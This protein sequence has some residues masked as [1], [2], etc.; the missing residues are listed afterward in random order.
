MT[1]NTNHTTLSGFIAA[2]QSQLNLNDDDV[3]KAM[4]NISTQVYTMIKS[5]HAK[6]PY[7]LIESLA[8][9]LQMAKADLLTSVLGYE[10]PALL[11]LVRQTWS[12][13]TLTRN[14]RTL[15]EAFRSLTAG[16]DVTPVVMDGRNV[17]A[18]VTA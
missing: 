15:V 12:M 7:N 10:A 14:E 9:A 8:S 11:A 17:I 2:R 18:L 1:D 6:L 13:T 5:G 3:A 16:K 4:G